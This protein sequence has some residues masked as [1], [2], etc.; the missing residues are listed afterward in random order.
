MIMLVWSYPRGPNG[1]LG[2]RDKLISRGWAKS[3]LSHKCFKKRNTKCDTKTA[4]LFYHTTAAC[5]CSMG[6]SSC[7]VRPSTHTSHRSNIYVLTF[8]FALVNSHAALKA[9]LLSAVS[10]NNI[11]PACRVHGY[12]DAG[13]CV[14]VAGYY[15]DD[16]VETR[17]LAT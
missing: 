12:W 8:S 11:L 6:W 7:L 4:T 14:Q 1:I 17:R 3:V 15:G 9:T 5:S 10:E 2:F 16:T 13:L